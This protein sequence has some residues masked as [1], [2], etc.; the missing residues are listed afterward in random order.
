MY[1]SNDIPGVIGGGMMNNN[2]NSGTHVNSSFSTHQQNSAQQLQV[3]SQSQSQQ[4]L[5]KQ[6]V[7]QPQLLNYSIHVSNY[8]LIL[9]FLY[10]ICFMESDIDFKISSS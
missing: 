3:Q 8:I 4:L 10:C 9:F 1:L 7:A 6:S 2:S 5:Q